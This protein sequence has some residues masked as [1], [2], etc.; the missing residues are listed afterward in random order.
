MLILWNIY[1]IKLL[2]SAARVIDTLGLCDNRNF[3]I[4][5]SQ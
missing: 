4:C 1:L 5:L 2:N 3:P